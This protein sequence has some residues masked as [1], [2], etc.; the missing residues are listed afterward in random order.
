MD[1]SGFFESDATE[2][3]C[4]GVDALMYDDELYEL[5][6]GG[7]REAITINVMFKPLSSTMW[8][9]VL[10]LSKTQNKIQ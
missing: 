10:A 5:G 1:G 2:Q 6:P 8:V 9:N 4:I 7:M 3:L